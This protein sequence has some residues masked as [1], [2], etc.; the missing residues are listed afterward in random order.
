MPKL[1]HVCITVYVMSPNSIMHNTNCY[2]F[3]WGFT[4][5]QFSITVQWASE[6]DI[7]L[8]DFTFLQDFFLYLS[9]L[10]LLFTIKQNTKKSLAWMKGKLNPIGSL[11][12]FVL[13]IEHIRFWVPLFVTE[14]NPICHCHLNLCM[15]GRS[16]G[17]KIH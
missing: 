7:F 17:I 9:L 2:N 4:E 12:L 14:K 6:N 15:Q 10:L 3:L 1:H 8:P 11:F 16:L 13:S 5:K